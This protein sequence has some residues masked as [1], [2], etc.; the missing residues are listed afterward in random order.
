MGIR[1]DSISH[2]RNLVIETDSRVH[3]AAQAVGSHLPGGLLVLVEILDQEGQLV[4]PELARGTLTPILDDDGVG[5]RIAGIP[6]RRHETVEPVIRQIDPEHQ[7]RGGNSRLD[8]RNIGIPGGL[9][10][11][12]TRKILG[13]DE[14]IVDGLGAGADKGVAVIGAVIEGPE[15]SVTSARSIPGSGDLVAPAPRLIVGH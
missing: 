14:G 6:D 2:G 15:L 10:V 11:A 13:A 12:D 8:A 5:M 9:R 3:A 7:A 1:S 4:L